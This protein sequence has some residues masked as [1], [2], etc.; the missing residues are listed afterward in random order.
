M[1]RTFTERAERAKQNGRPFLF[2]RTLE[3]KK[4]EVTKEMA[5]HER[6]EETK[7]GAKK[8]HMCA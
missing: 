2:P 7:R 6:Q 5:K 3:Q 8:G 4:N 1:K